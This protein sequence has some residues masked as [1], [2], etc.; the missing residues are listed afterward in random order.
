MGIRIL[1][2]AFELRLPSALISFQRSALRCAFNLPLS[3]ASVTKFF[4]DRPL[5][6]VHYQING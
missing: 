4:N 3:A 6:S 2:F 5:L 1:S